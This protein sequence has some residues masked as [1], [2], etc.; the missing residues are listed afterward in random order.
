[1]TKNVQHHKGQHYRGTKQCKSETAETC[2]REEAHKNI[3]IEANQ[4][5]H[6]AQLRG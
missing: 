6:A 3:D 4:P 1:M 5:A 2:V